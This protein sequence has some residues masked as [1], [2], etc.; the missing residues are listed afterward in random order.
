MKTRFVVFTISLCLALSMTLYAASEEQTG[1]YPAL[2]EEISKIVEENFY[3]PAQIARDFPSIKDR[4]K[5]QVV[6]VSTP[7]AFATLVNAM[8]RELHASH[9]YYLTPDDYEYYQLGALFVT[10]PEIGALF[11]GQDVMY[12][13]VGIMTQPI[14]EK[15]YIT[16]VLAGSVAEKAGLLQGD[17]ILSVD[18]KSY[19]PIASLR[20]AADVAFEIRRGEQAEPQII[21]MRP[22]LVNPKQ[23]MLEAE[24][25]S[26]R[27]IE[28]EGQKIGYIHI[29]S[30]AG[31]EYHQELLDAIMWGTLQEADALIIDLRYGLGGAN[32][33]YL[34]I[35]DRNIP[36]LSV[37]NRD[38]EDLIVDSQ[39]RKPAVYLVNKFTRSGKELLAFG[40]KKY[41]LA[42]VIGENTAGQTLG[43]R[44]F[45]LSNRDALFLAGQSSRIDGVSLEGVGVAPDIEV[46][47]DIRYCHGH[48]L[49]IEKAI[50]YLVE[51]LTTAKTAVK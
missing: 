35:F 49:Q 44:L 3:N 19:T 12:P 38:G 34:S 1:S 14:A 42:T 24:R 7:Q 48:D 16:T 25:A 37:Q 23:E 13:T 47:F 17:E 11:G 5:E 32:P 22:V 29:Y 9:T 36:V 28:K 8:L 18:G 27:L 15:I 43:G 21:V 4:Y 10:I 6:Q 2:F 30:Y 26:V 45:P 46:P 51:Q 31:E 50:D 33:Y 41:R 40:A 20:S 39:W